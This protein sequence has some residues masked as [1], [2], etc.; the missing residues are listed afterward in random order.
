M[1]EPVM[2]RAAKKVKSTSTQEHPAQAAFDEQPGRKLRWVAPLEQ[3]TDEAKF[4]IKLPRQGQKHWPTV[5]KVYENKDG[6]WS[7]RIDDQ[8]SL[9]GRLYMEPNPFYMGDEAAAKVKEERAA[10]R[11]A[12]ADLADSPIG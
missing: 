2:A 6:S 4:R 9:S 1:K 5:A 7:I 10:N 8:I 12:L 11:A 3:Q